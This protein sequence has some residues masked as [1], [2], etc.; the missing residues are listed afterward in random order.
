MKGEGAV[1]HSTATRRFKEFRSGY[2]DLDGQAFSNG[3]KTAI[4][5]VSIFISFVCFWS[6]EAN[7]GSSG[8]S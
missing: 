7:L 2:L 4:F 1:D 8:I 3:P 6:R 5:F